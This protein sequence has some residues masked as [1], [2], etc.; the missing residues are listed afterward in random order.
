MPGS[1]RMPFRSAFRS[2][3]SARRDGPTYGRLIADQVAA[4]TSGWTPFDP[5]LASSRP[6]H[7]GFPTRVATTVPRFLCSRD[8]HEAMSAE[9][10]VSLPFPTED[11][12][13]L[14][15]GRPS[16]P[17]LRVRVGINVGVIAFEG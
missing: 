14:S 13:T 9:S 5:D 7:I 12:R 11:F 6:A 2:L 8:E 10:K 1:R 3:P 15:S 17:R 16:V 4:R